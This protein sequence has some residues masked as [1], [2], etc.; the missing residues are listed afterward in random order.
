MITSSDQKRVAFNHSQKPSTLLPHTF[1]SYHT[2][3]IFFHLNKKN[4]IQNVHPV[5]DHLE[6]GWMVIYSSFL[7]DEPALLSDDFSE[8]DVV[9]DSLSDDFFSVDPL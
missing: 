1:N 3:S 2:T 8:D 6:R 9:E 7:P 5:F 4:R